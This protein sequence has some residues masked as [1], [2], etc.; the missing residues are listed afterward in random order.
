MFALNGSEW[1]KRTSLRDSPEQFRRFIQEDKSIRRLPDTDWI[2]LGGP[3]PLIA[4]RHLPKNLLQ[5]LLTKQLMG[6]F[7]L[8]S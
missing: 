4:E 7:K 1:D 6:T 8:A 2:I 3:E 5:D